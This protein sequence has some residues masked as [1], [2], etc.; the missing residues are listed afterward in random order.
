MKLKNVIKLN[1]D[2]QHEL[3]WNVNVVNPVSVLRIGFRRYKHVPLNDHNYRDADYIKRLFFE[4]DLESLLLGVT[5]CFN[6]PLSKIMTMRFVMLLRCIKTIKNDIENDT[7]EQNKLNF[8]SDKQTQMAMKMS[9][10]EVMNQFGIYN[11]IE[12]LSGGDKK[13]WNYFENLKYSNI[14]LM[15]AFNTMSNDLNKRFQK[16]YEQLNKVS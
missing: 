3:F 6:I 1:E 13:K 10:S 12:T 2:E 14:K 8:F 7:I 4:D 9:K 15:I 16:N 5:E 11:V